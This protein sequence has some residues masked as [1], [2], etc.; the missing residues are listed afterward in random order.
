MISSVSVEPSKPGLAK[1]AGTE[2]I[3]VKVQST[4]AVP[5]TAARS[6]MALKS[7]SVSWPKF[8]NTWSMVTVWGRVVIVVGVMLLA[9]PIWSW[10]QAA[11]SLR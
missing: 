4:P 5:K 3:E 1:A 10:M 6:S 9:A 2:V 7:N 8:S 11:A